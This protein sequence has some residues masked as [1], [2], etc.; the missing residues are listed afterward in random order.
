MTNQSP[1]GGHLLPLFL[2][3]ELVTA[4]SLAQIL[5]RS[6][7]PGILTILHG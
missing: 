3:P 5:M 2:S 1:L 7:E 4:A 6:Q